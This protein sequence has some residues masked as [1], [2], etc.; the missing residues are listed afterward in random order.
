[1]LILDS[2]IAG[3]FIEIMANREVIFAEGSMGSHV[4]SDMIFKINLAVVPSKTS[5]LTNAPHKSMPLKIS[6]KN[7]VG[8]ANELPAENSSDAEGKYSIPDR[9]GFSNKAANDITLDNSMFRPV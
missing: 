2:S 5:A 4:L 3:R 9:N 6:P 7:G 1:M 8:L